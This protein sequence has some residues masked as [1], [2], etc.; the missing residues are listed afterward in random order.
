[1]IFDRTDKRIA[2]GR[3]FLV[4]DSLTL[5]DIALAAGTAPMVL[6]DAYAALLPP[7]ERV[8]AELQAMVREM[9]QHLTA[10]FAEEIYAL[11]AASP[12]P[13]AASHQFS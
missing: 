1:M 2:N 5:G 6:P 10:K 11:R 7:L 12:I 13:V 8:P 4:G 9:R 3:W